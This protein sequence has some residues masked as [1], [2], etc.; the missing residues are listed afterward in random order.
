M[1]RAAG[2]TLLA[3]GVAVAGLWVWSGWSLIE[4]YCGAMV[5]ASGGRVEIF[6]L[7]ARSYGFGVD[8]WP[9]IG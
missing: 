5:R 6:V 7:K 2:W 1:R 4:V 8:L 9:E 3:F